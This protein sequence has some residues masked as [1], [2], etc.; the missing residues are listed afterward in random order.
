MV[1]L[2][3]TALLAQ[4]RQAPV[5]RD[6]SNPGTKLRV[7]FKAMQPRES[8]QK[9]ILAHIVQVVLS[10][11]GAAYC[12]HI[13]EMLLIELCERVFIPQARCRDKFGLIPAC[14]PLKPLKSA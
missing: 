3:V 9:C 14:S 5:C 1:R 12:L 7:T 4:N 8:Q 13:A 6:T 2:P 10:K 11:N